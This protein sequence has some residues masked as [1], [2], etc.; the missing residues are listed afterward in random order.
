MPAPE[1]STAIEESKI[2]EISNWIIE[3]SL[4]GID[5]DKLV[6][7]FCERVVEAGIPLNRAQIACSFLHPMFRAFSVSW[8]PDRGVERSRFAHANA[9]TDAWLRSPFKAVVE[10]DTKEIRA[11]IY[12]GEGVNRFPVLQE[13]KEQGFTD[14]LVTSTRYSDIR[15]PGEDYLDGSMSSWTTNRPDGYSDDQLDALRRLIQRLN[16]GLK[17]YVREMTTQNMLSAYL[18]NHAGNRVLQGQIQLGDGDMIN[19]A[20]WFSDMRASTSTADRVAPDLFLDRLNRYFQCTAGAVLDHGGE[21]LRFIGDAVLA[22]FP[23]SGPGGAERATR[24]AVSAAKDAVRRLEAHNNNLPENDPQPLEFGLGLHV[25]NVL[26]G[27]IGVPERVEFSVIG[28][29]AN[30]VARLQDLTKELETRIVASNAF[31]SLTQ[32]DWEPLGSHRLRGVSEPQPVYGLRT[33]VALYP[34]E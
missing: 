15:G 30:E 11:R 13:L 26:F 29:T 12:R 20:I 18:G 23:I 8:N 9:N 3:V 21:V 7:G 34:Q 1:Y 28:P 16:I 22:I 14:Y 27:N 6:K 10:D 17:I 5:A 31:S 33:T 24:M 32:A 25:G 2:A 19:A 4:D